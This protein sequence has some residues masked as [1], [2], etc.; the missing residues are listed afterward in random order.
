MTRFSRKNRT[1]IEFKGR[2]GMTD[3]F[4]DV[5]KELH[6]INDAEYDYIIEFSTD[7]E[8]GIFIP[9]YKTFS[10]LK[11]VINFV[12]KKLEEYYINKE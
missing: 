2:G 9:N 4:D 3:A 12:N 10:D 11:N 5:M 1:D 6:R 8:L 7:E